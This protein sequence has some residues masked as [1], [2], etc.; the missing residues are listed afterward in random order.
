MLSRLS[1]SINTNGLVPRSK[2]YTVT[3]LEA[4]EQ[5]ELHYIISISISQADLYAPNRSLNFD[6][7][8][9]TNPYHL[10][11]MSAKKGLVVNTWRPLLHHTI[12][13]RFPAEKLQWAAFLPS[14]MY[15]K[16]A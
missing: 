6:L 5:G 1:G 9:E 13:Y 4:F 15:G 12:L 14:S 7:H 2:Q 16:I 8:G 3:C 11:R 10:V